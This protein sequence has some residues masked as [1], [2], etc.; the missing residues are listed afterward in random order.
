MKRVADTS[1]LI[2]RLVADAKP[3][4]RLR[5]PALRAC[6]WLLAVGA[7]GVAGILLFA[8]VSEFI[9]RIGDTALAIEWVATIVTGILAVVA[10]FQLSLP[11]RSPAW[12]LLPLPSLALWIGTS[13]Y[14]C[15][16]NW[17]MTGPTGWE[18][19]ESANCL[20]FILA[21]SVPLSV[22]ILLVLRRAMPLEPV[23]VAAMGA[24]GVAALAAGALQFFHPFDVTFL[25]LG[26]HL[27]AIALI[28]GGVSAVEHFSVRSRF[29]RV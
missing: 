29:G 6:L 10:S 16:R 15:Y 19:G 4:K 27:G 13:G 1:T 12:V 17:I 3:V 21:V 14:S 7:A 2:R 9:E 5:S 11:D 24:L 22:S 23:R 18:L 26:L 20:M 25:D 28:V 8:N